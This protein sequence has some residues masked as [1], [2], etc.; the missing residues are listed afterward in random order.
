MRPITESVA[1]NAAQTI[2]AAGVTT[3]ATEVT[4]AT[5]VIKFPRNMKLQMTGY[6]RIYA[7]AS[8]YGQVQATVDGIPLGMPSTF[9]LGFSG[10][11]DLTVPIGGNYG[12]S[13]DGLSLGPGAHTIRVMVQPY[14]NG[15]IVIAEFVTWNVTQWGV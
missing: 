4:A 2:G 15:N 5:K 11:F 3:P 7:A 9:G 1:V 8:A 12:D 14:N 6:V 10:N 13:S